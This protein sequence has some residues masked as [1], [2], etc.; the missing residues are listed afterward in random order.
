MRNNSSVNNKRS[1]KVC[2]QNQGSFD[3]NT[4]GFVKDFTNNNLS[5]ANGAP[6]PPAVNV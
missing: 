2:P 1:K 5:Q 6:E 3:P 4:Q